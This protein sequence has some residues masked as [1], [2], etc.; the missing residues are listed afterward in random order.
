[1]IR[2]V[3]LLNVICTDNMNKD[4]FNANIIW[5]VVHNLNRKV[6]GGILILFAFNTAWTTIRL[7]KI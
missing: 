3:T 2:H 7:S 5:S 1:M 4:T 6:A